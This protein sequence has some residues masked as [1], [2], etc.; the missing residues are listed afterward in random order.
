[1]GG[2]GPRPAPTMVGGVSW[3][4]CG[5]ENG[6]GRRLRLDRAVG[7]RGC[8]DSGRPV[9]A[10]RKELLYARRRHCRRQVRSQMQGGLGAIFSSGARQA[11][12]HVDEREENAQQARPRVITQPCPAGG[13]LGEDHGS[14]REELADFGAP[15]AVD[16]TE[17]RL[18]ANLGTLSLHLAEEMKRA[19]SFLFEHWGY[20][21]TT[22]WMLA[23]RVHGAYFVHT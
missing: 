12:A 7:R 11:L 3:P 16:S 2:A 17:Q 21:A 15:A 6:V 19:E 1:M 14:C 18:A 4:A 10:P 20:G 23:S 9:P 22:K 13:E 5:R 8:R